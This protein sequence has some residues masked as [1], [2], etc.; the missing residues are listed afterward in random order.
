MAASRRCMV[1]L[2]AG[3]GITALL[4]GCAAPERG[5]PVPE[6]YSAAATV[7]GVANERFFPSLD[8]K[9]IQ[10]EL[11]DAV[12]RAPDFQ[13]YESNALLPQLELLALSGGGENGA[14]GAGLLC[15]W[16]A[17]GTRPEFNMV[18]GVSTGALI[19]PFAF[20][21]SGYDEQLRAVF[22]GLT[23]DELLKSRPYTAALFDDG[24]IDNAPLFLTISRHINEAMLAEIAAAYDKGRLLFI[25]TTDLDAQLPVMWNIGAIAKS[26]HP[27]ALDTVRRI[28]LASAAIPG[29]FPPTM[30]D[31]TLDGR[32]YQEMH[33]DG[34]TFAQAFLYPSAAVQNRRDRI[35][36]RQPVRPMAGYIIRNGRL[37]PEWADVQRR[38]INIAGRAISTMIAA[39]GYNDVAR[40]FNA[41]QRDNVAFNLA[42]IGPD[43]QE[44]LPSPF[45]QNF[46]R[47]LF[48]YGYQKALHGYEWASRPPF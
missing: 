37:H 8:M 35:A 29:A 21:G 25:S 30:F 41:T 36:R 44:V 19:A 16:T 17:S 15:G 7:L 46:M 42:Y 34:G 4:S 48:D 27:R 5:P 11:F 22:T 33:V 39:S 20:L 9:P 2:A 14:F 26:G 43:F 6:A 24:M 28:M 45:D 40:I 10:R 47:A 18:T 31:V 23:P 1:K 12:M 3:T 32:A 13:G 38:T